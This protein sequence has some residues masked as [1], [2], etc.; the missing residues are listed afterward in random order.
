MLSRYFDLKELDRIARRSRGKDEGPSLMSS[1][2]LIAQAPG[3]E[4]PWTFLRDR[5]GNCI[6]INEGLTKDCE[7]LFPSVMKIGDH[8][9]M[10]TG[11]DKWP[12][13]AA[14]AA[15]SVNGVYFDI[16]S[17]RGRKSEPGLRCTDIQPEADAMKV[18][19]GACNPDTGLFEA[20]ANVAVPGGW[21]VYHSQCPFDVGIFKRLSKEASA[22]TLSAA[23]NSALSSP[24]RVSA[25]SR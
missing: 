19:R 7:W 4:G 9:Y 24:K 5:S 6:N 8:G 13:T 18:L 25:N 10:L 15:F 11:G 1:S 2:M 21:H 12:P 14:W 16:P 23:L 22:V 20:V 17:R 3:V